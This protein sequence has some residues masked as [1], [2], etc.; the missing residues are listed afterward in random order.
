MNT[1]NNHFWDIRK[2]VIFRKTICISR[3]MVILWIV[4]KHD[5]VMLIITD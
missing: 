4:T 2:A 1:H 3:D 5:D